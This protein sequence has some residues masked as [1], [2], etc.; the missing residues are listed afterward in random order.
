MGNHCNLIRQLDTIKMSIRKIL[1]QPRLTQVRSIYLHS[2]TRVA[3][4]KRDP[5]QAFTT[6]TGIKYGISEENLKYIKGFLGDKYGISDELALQVI[7]HKSFGNG[8]K[9]FNEKLG[10]MG[11]KIM[12]LFFAKYVTSTKTPNEMTING[13]N[14]DPLGSPMAKELTARLS[15]GLFAKQNQLN[16]IMFWKSFNHDLSFESSGELRI[17][18]QMIYALVGAVTFT[19]GKQVA[20]QFLHEKFLNANPSIEDITAR[21]IE[22]N[23]Q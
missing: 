15:N 2:G 20:E 22:K 5:E 21:I 12:N 10:V 8:I 6:N 3:G 13:L 4:L 19:H 23:S 17:S 14:L 18:A 1:A 9:P 16:T 7:T 11:S